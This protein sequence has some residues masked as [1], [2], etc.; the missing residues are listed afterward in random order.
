MSDP[1]NKVPII[2]LPENVKIDFEFDKMLKIFLKQ[3]D[4]S[5]I[6]KEVKMR[7]YYNKPSELRHKIE[8]SIKRQRVL[9]R[10]N[11]RKK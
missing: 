9:E 5:G 7:R 11:R 8:G 2:N 1:K 3:V 10:R 4:R 6:L